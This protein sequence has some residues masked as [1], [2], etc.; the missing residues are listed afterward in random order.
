MIKKLT[1]MVEEHGMS[2]LWI[3]IFYPI[4]MIPMTS[5]IL[6]G[7]IAN[8][9]KSLVFQKWKYLTGNNK[10]SSLNNYFY[11]GQSL[12][13]NKFG[14]FGDSS[15][16]NGPEKFSLK[17]WFHCTKLSLNIFSNAGVTFSLFI[18]MIVWSSSWVLMTETITHTQLMLLAIA[19]TS[20]YYFASFID[21][22]NYNILGWALL[23]IALHGLL[24]GNFFLFGSII[25]LMSFLSFTSIFVMGFAT[26]VF[27]IYWQSAAPLLFAF[28]AIIKS[29]IPIILSIK[30]NAAQKV[31]GAIGAHKNVKYARADSVASFTTS[32]FYLLVLNLTFMINYYL[33]FGIDNYFILMVIGCSLYIVNNIIARFADYQTFWILMLTI[34]LLSVWEKD[35]ELIDFIIFGLAIN[36]IYIFLDFSGTWKLIAPQTRKP[37]SS[38]KL[39]KKLNTFF[40]RVEPN[41]TVLGAYKNPHN[42]YFNLFDGL[43]V[44]VQP[45]EYS[46]MEN[47]LSLFPSFHYI[48]E[49]NDVKK[50][51]DTIWCETLDDTLKAC[52]HFNIEYVLFPEHGE[53]QLSKEYF[54]HFEVFDVLDLDEY[55]DGLT[56][57]LL[58]KKKS[59][60]C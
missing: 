33:S 27:C 1:K 37:Y 39:N 12:N 30:M 14:R 55:H 9:I 36:P 3:L 35:L 4:L 28:P 42:N 13:I 40:I 54:D 22:Q 7:S 24:T 23:P 2:Q 58:K 6:L 26:V 32:F 44:I 38:E 51:D 5:F 56:L 50:N 20:T 48:V 52:A 53:R 49:H 19:F 18:S 29:I 41:S 59:I 25:V 21:A 46:A 47:S 45:I 11:F 43:R 8:I 17:N 60:L 31:G 10:S 34:F 16:L 57:K 15:L